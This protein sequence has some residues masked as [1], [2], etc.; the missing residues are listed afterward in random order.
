V[1]LIS[2]LMTLSSFIFFSNFDI[3]YFVTSAWVIPFMSSLYSLS[4]AFSVVLMSVPQKCPSG[5]QI[6]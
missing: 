3:V 1:P 2:G 5:T 6:I 4:H